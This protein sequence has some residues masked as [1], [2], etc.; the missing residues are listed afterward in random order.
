MR[1][2]EDCGEYCSREC[3]E[4][5]VS[6]GKNMSECKYCGKEF[7]VK[8]SWIDEKYFEIA[9]ERIESHEVTE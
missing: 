9:R 4:Q 7:K 8:Q 1:E 2:C 6:G 5:I 3:Y